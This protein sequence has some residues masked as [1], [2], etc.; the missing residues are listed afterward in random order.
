MFATS[1]RIVEML[2]GIALLMS[3]IVLPVAAVAARDDRS[4]LEYV[5][6]RTTEVARTSRLTQ[7]PPAWRGLPAAHPT[8]GC[9]R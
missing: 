9:A 3:G 5:L 2:G 1:A 7:R 4:R 6:A 8:T